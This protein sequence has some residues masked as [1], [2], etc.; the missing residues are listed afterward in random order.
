MAGKP[1]GGKGG[2]GGGPKTYT[3]KIEVTPL[4]EITRG[5][6]RV[7][8]VKITVLSGT[9]A[10]SGVEVRIINLEN[11]KE[12]GRA[13]TLADGDVVF[14]K[15]AFKMLSEEQKRDV[16]FALT[17]TEGAITHTW[18]ITV[19]SITGDTK[20]EESAPNFSVKHYGDNGRYTFHIM[21]EPKGVYEVCI[22]EGSQLRQTI[23]TATDGTLEYDAL[24][25]KEKERRFTFTLLAGGKPTHK[26]TTVCLNGP[27][28]P[29][30]VTFAEMNAKVKRGK[31]ESEGSYLKR[32]FKQTKK[33]VK[34]REEVV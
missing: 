28:K 31:K 20:E 12:I 7:F 26:Q 19:P 25:F 4:T 5:D 10:K 6:K 18:P 11:G 34:E 1:Y 33:T 22:E 13:K 17:G 9:W 3:K 27:P 15:I 30:S 32:F 14:D 21:V 2:G 29:E 24:P 8:P 16:Q 23:D